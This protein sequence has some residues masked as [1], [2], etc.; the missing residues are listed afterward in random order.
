MLP[1]S[2]AALVVMALVAPAAASASAFGA[3]PAEVWQAGGKS[4]SWQSSFLESQGRSVR[5]GGQ[6]RT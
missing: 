2:S 1:S 5:L 3:S 4:F 6:T